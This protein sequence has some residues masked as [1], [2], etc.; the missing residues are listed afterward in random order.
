MDLTTTQKLKGLETRKAKA[1]AEWR[2]L[3]DDRQRV[4]AAFTSKQQEIDFLTSEINALIQREAERGLVVSEH[5]VLQ[6]LRR[7]GGVDVDAV[8]KAIVPEDVATQIETLGAGRY[9]V[10]QSDKT[11]FLIVRGGKVVTVE[12]E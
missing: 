5:A 9:P 10:V 8:T 1:I 7:V 11:Y 4:L 6:Y 3:K 2:V 12:L